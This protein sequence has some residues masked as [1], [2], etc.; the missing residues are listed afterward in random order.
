MGPRTKVL[1]LSSIV[2][3]VLTTYLNHSQVRFLGQTRTCVNFIMRTYNVVVT[4]L[5]FKPTILIICQADSP[6]PLLAT[7]PQCTHCL[8]DYYYHHFQMILYSGEFKKAN[9]EKFI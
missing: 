9:I 2:K 3:Q 5:G 7:A 4:C 1:K 8:I 6:Y